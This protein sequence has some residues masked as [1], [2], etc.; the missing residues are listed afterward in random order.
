MY[1]DPIEVDHGIV[2]Y[3][4]TEKEDGNLQSAR[5]HAKTA[6]DFGMSFDP[7]SLA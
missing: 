3:A 7:V 6:Q 4:V 1:V 5:G 2:H